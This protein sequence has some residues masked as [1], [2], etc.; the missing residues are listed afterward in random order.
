M[1]DERPRERDSEDQ[2]ERR[3]DDRGERGDRMEPCTKCGMQVRRSEMAIHLAHAHN[4][5]P[6]GEKRRRGGGR[7][8]R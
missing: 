4:I 7:D 3:D 1:T 2:G 6:A 8:R 5:G